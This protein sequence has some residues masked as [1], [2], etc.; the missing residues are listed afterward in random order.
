MV[1]LVFV[2]YTFSL[3]KPASWTADTAFPELLGYGIVPGLI[4]G[5]NCFLGG[6]VCGVMFLLL[7]GAGSV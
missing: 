2:A 5:F 6:A 7:G 3:Q 4:L 1:G